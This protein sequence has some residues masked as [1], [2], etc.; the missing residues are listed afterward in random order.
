MKKPIL[1]MVIL[2]T[3]VAIAWATGAIWIN[4]SNRITLGLPMN[5]ADNI[6]L[7]DDGTTV[8][9]NLKDNAGTHSMTYTDIK[10]VT[11]GKQQNVVTI[12]F[13]GT[14][15][16][17]VNPFAFQGV[18]IEKIGAN[19]T[20][21]STASDNIRYELSGTTT[22]GSVTFTC[23]ADFTLALKGV[24]I[25]NTTGSAINIT[26]SG[27]TTVELIDGYT[28]S[29]V[30]GTAGANGCI[31][32]K[33]S[34]LFNGNGTLNVTGNTKHGVAAKQNIE[35]ASGVVNIV[36]SV[37]DGIHSGDVFVMNGGS[38]T[39]QGVG[40]DCIDG[41]AGTIEINNGTLNLNVNTAD[42]KGIKADDS[43][44]VNGG[45]IDVTMPA[46]QGKAFKT[47]A[48]MIVNGG[49]IKI[50]ASGNA[51][52]VNYD[53]SYCTAIKTDGNFNM[54]AGVITITHSGM[55][56]KG[57]SSDGDATFD[58]GEVNITTTGNGSTYTASTGT[59]T[60]CSTCITANGNIYLNGG[61]FNLVSSGTAGKCIKTDLQII[62]NPASNDALV[63]NAE[64]KGS[65]LGSSGSGGG[66]GGRPGGGGGRPGSGTSSSSDSNSSPKV[67][68]SE[69]NMTITGGVF[70][71][72]STSEGGEGLESKGTMTIKGGDFY[73]Q[74]YD[75]CINAATAL[76]ISG[77][78]IRA[79]STGNDA[80]DSNGTMTISGGLLLANGTSEPEEGL[81][82]DKSSQLQIT[83][84]TIINQRGNMLNITTSQCKVP[85]VRYSSSIAA[86]ALITITDSNGNHIISFKSPQRMSQG[87][88]ITHPSLILG[89]SYK[90]YTSGMVTGG[91]VFNEVTDSGTYTPG[92]LVKSFTVSSTM[93]SL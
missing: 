33:G 85:T 44:T 13:D 30:D 90:L 64:T 40:G 7:S 50:T 83:G 67:I 2:M 24:N 37:S 21:T 82:V 56:G 5:K 65:Q 42:T 46:D 49:N 45:T 93:T 14:D 36:S 86:G 57:I 87:C 60:Y 11:F 3:S 27:N 69:G 16:D 29:I 1:F 20:V 25:T 78:N 68:K 12:T 28:S 75:D 92:T 79:V 77:G 53:P 35:I 34:M 52:V 62:A 66:P 15:A 51:V 76:N 39:M 48:S 18:S 4:Q 73:F 26:S 80:I 61:N 47:S 38:V 43:I 22:D 17:I 91:N 89:K 88:Y 8:N 58:G 31:Y 59:D 10:N 71:L 9:F 19:I 23:D 72:K 55:G 70:T 54:S 41:D 32:S 6:T 81:D 84:G 63:V 74:T